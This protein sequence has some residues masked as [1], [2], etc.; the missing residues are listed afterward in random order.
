MTRVP[1][2]TPE[3]LERAAQTAAKAFKSWSRTS[4][5]HRQQILL[6]YQHL[7]KHHLPDLA[8]SIVLEQGKT[9]ADALGDVGRGL[10][11]V[12]SLCALPNEM[13]GDKLEVSRDMDTYV[14]RSPLGVGAVICP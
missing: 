6:K 13:T 5:L 9:Y 7:I 8:R 10:Q 1:Q 14:R 4:L 2:S 3:E 11:V 12:E